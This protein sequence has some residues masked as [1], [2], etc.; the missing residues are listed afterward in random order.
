MLA[1]SIIY[2]PVKVRI[3]KWKRSWEKPHTALWIKSRPE[4]EEPAENSQLYYKN[5]ATI[6][7]FLVAICSTEI[8]YL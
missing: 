8:L 1:H 7:V 4:L 6:V 5:V 3:E 2:R